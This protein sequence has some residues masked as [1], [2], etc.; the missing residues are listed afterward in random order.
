MTQALNSAGMRYKLTNG[1][2]QIEVLS[3][4]ASQ[5]NVAL[6]SKGLS[7][8]SQPGMEIFDKTSLAM[9]DFQQQVDYQRAVQGEIDRRDHADRRDHEC[10]RPA[11]LPDRHAVPRPDLEGERRG[12]PDDRH[13]ARSVDRLRRRASRRSERQGPQHLERDDHRR[14][15]RAALAEREL[16]R[17]NERAQ[18]ARSRAALLGRAGSSDQLDAH[19]DARPGQGARTGPVGSQR[20]PDDARQDD[21]RQEGHADHQADHG[22]DAHERRRRHGDAGRPTRRSPRAPAAA[23]AA[24]RTT[25]TS[26]ARPRSASTRPSS[27]RWSRPGRSTGSRSR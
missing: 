13:A 23:P 26:P 24:S 27:A 8:G 1:G 2:T 20:R 15:G 11:R 19:L 25:R 5:A 7:Q 10:R 18:Q 12:A 16:G 21:V 9:T 6:A 17:R 22:G 4:Q 3:S 14:H